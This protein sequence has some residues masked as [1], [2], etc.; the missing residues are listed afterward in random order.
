MVDT[1]FSA[2]TAAAGAA[3]ANEFGINEAGTSK[4]VTALQVKTYVSSSPT[5]VTPIL[6]TPQSGTLTNCSG[7]PLS[8]LT[9]LPSFTHYVPCVME[10]PNDTVAYPDVFTLGDAGAKITGFWLPNSGTSAINFKCVVP[11]DLHATPASAV[12]IYMIPRT[13]V[14]NSTV[15]LTISRLYVNTAEDADAA[16]TAE[17]AVDVDIT[18]TLDNLTIY[19]Y[20]LT[21]EPT[22]GELF[23][24]LLTRTP[25]AANDDFTEDLL[26]VAIILKIER[27]TTT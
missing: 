12:Q 4:K 23:E 19:S 22:A 20:D 7:L 2:L 10:V 9:A 24:G 8:G 14:A 13:T 27:T 21:A 18:S 17:S 15:N 1:K 3:D 6:G 25:G 16:Y 5:L 26:I 11:E